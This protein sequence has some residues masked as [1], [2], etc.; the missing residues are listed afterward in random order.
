MQ[1]AMMYKATTPTLAIGTKKIPN[2]RYSDSPEAFQSERQHIHGPVGLQGWTNEEEGGRQQQHELGAQDLCRTAA[3]PKLKGAARV[4]K[5]LLKR[6][7][8][9]ED[10]CLL[11]IRRGCTEGGILPF[12]LTYHYM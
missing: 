7:D 1:P 4:P 9:G 5:G 10:G 11:M 6:K 12:L 8:V 3:G 2:H